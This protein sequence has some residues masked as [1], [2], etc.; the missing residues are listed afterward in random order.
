MP[1][2]DYPEAVSSS[3]LILEEGYG[4]VSSSNLILVGI[5]ATSPSAWFFLVSHTSV[6]TVPY[7]GPLLLRA[8]LTDCFYCLTITVEERR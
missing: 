3:N 1:G 5:Y 4:T 6:G 7:Y 2:T 8:V